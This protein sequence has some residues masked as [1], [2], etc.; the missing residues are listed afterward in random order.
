MACVRVEAQDAAYLFLR[1]CAGR[2]AAMARDRAR[3]VGRC[4]EYHIAIEAPQ[5]PPEVG[6]P[7]AYVLL[8]VE[9]IANTEALD[10]AELYAASWVCS[11]RIVAINCATRSA[12]SG[13]CSS[14]TLEAVGMSALRGSTGRLFT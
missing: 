8:Q 11:A 7:A 3:V 12:K 5:Q 4:S 1:L 14:G 2:H 9:A 13:I 10:E 6:R